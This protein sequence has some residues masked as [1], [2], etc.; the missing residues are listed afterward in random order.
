MAITNKELQI[1][2]KSY[3]NKDFQA[4]YT[5][6]LNY[7]E[8]LSKRFSPANT[9]ESDPFVVLLKLVAFVTDKVNY[10]IDKNIL[11]RFMLSCTQEKSMKELTSILGYNMHYYKA[12]YTDVIFKHSLVTSKGEEVKKDIIIPRFS[13]VTN[14]KDVQYVTISNANIHKETGV[15]EATTVLQGKIKTLSV[16]GNE[17]IQLE[18]IQNNKLYF[19]E[20]YVAENGV[21]V[22]SQNSTEWTQ[23]DNL[24]NCTYG[25]LVYK[26]SFDGMIN[27]PYLEFP[28]WVSEIIG[29]GITIKYIVTDGSKGNIGVKELIN[30]TRLTKDD[31]IDDKEIKVVNLSPANTGCDIET[32][33]ESYEGFK[34]VVGTFDT[35]V[36]CRD[37]ANYIYRQLEDLIS[38]VQVSDRRNDINY[39]LNVLEYDDY[40]LTVESE[41]QNWPKVKKNGQSIS[42]NDIAL[43]PLKPLTNL[44]FTGLKGSQDLN[45]PAGGYD[46]AYRIL[47][48]TRQIKNRLEYVKSLNHDYIEF[49]TEH[50]KDV[51]S[52]S[53]DRYGDLLQIRD[54]YIL[55]VII[56]TSY[57]LNVLEQVDV[58]YNIKNALIKNF[59]SRTLD[60][61]EEIPFSSIVDVIMQSDTRITNVVLGDPD[62]KISFIEKTTDG[63]V[64][65]TESDSNYNFWV[66]YIITKNIL[67]GRVYLYDY[68]EDFVYDFSQ[69][70]IEK[71]NNI[72]SITTECGIG[73]ISENYSLK[74]N[75]VVQ[76]L[77]PSL[78]T[79]KGIYTYGINYNTNVQGNILAETDFKLTGG[80]YISFLY[81]SESGENVVELYTA[82][83]YIKATGAYASLEELTDDVIIYSNENILHITGEITGAGVTVLADL[84]GRDLSKYQEA[85][86]KAFEKA[87]I[88]IPVLEAKQITNNQ[89][90]I[91]KKFNKEIINKTRYCYWIM[92]NID[93]KI[94]WVN[95][96]YLLKEN[97]YLFISDLTLSNLYSYSSGTT[98]KKTAV[99]TIL[100]KQGIIKDVKDVDDIS[101]NGLD[102]L[103]DYFVKIPFTTSDNLEIT[104]NDIITLTEGSK[105]QVEGA[106]LTVPNND[107]ALINEE[108][109]V[110]YIYPG[111]TVSKKLEVKNNL[112][113]WKVRSILDLNMGP[114]V[115][116]RIEGN[117]KIIITEAS[118]DGVSPDRTTSLQ[119]TNIK[120]SI[121]INCAGGKNIDVSYKNLN[122]QTCYPNLITYTDATS[123]VADLIKIDDYIYTYTPNVLNETTTEDI[124][125]TITLNIPASNW[126][127]IMIYRK[128]LSDSA[129]SVKIKYKIGEDGTLTELTDYFKV[130]KIENSNIIT[131]ELSGTKDQLSYIKLY[132]SKPM[133]IKGLNSLLGEEY[134]FDDAMKVFGDN[135]KN[136]FYPSPN[137]DASKLVNIS[138]TYDLRHPKSYL[139]Y[140]NVA[141][142]YVI[143]KIDFELST[144]DIAANCKLTR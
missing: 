59:N 128:N 133:I 105:I 119:N 57:K 43:Y 11:E 132:I 122:L 22:I 76:F 5:E 78:I 91:H 104:I 60:W 29:S 89:Q 84:T 97:E 138:K 1:S 103:K 144:F 118:P 26:F 63:S 15:S 10:N 69:Q 36:T 52:D 95:N 6:L 73:A 49:S 106:S 2:N 16:L 98:L 55:N 25:S 74:Q 9:N 56:S 53:S 109:I 107:F 28:E 126:T 141:N 136:K 92:N 85:W 48:N 40:G 82:N 66:D 96:E 39:S 8:N 83:K 72:K 140:N 117:Q 71:K 54:N 4:I 120:S 114:E 50:K 127:Q 142:K 31:E 93:N 80:D 34:K 137:L 130:L 47:D 21:F 12:A 20:L 79:G 3:T 102:S 19:P 46:D 18:N 129:G 115:E 64:E 45:Y 94:N 139:D 111:E 75:E 58:Q 116:Q 123:S 33:S 30:V 121:L 23:V 113:N 124:Q 101:L 61:G 87:Q 86:Q 7:A 32:I 65:I 38:N 70:D 88:A 67:E 125:K 81:E 35:L 24:N 62:H 99:D 100:G 13:T 108:V 68:D 110:S 134:N 112:I 27:Q 131:L 135:I 17:L 44:N 41:I 42:A 51:M 37:Y 14:G 77:A 90:I 143:P